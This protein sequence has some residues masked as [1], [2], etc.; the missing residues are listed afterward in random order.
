MV[1]P[2][3][4]SG[5]ILLKIINSILITKGIGYVTYFHAFL[6]AIIIVN[7][8]SPTSLLLPFLIHHKISYFT[9]IKSSWKIILSLILVVFAFVCCHNYLLK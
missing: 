1:N 3:L 5:D 4:G 8:L 9:Y 2:V 7:L 6:S